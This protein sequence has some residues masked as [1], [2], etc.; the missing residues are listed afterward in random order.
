MNKLQSYMYLGVMVILLLAVAVVWS[1][2]REMTLNKENKSITAIKP[3]AL[4]DTS[5]TPPSVPEGELLPST[6]A[7]G[8]GSYTNTRY[9][10][11]FR[12]LRKEGHHVVTDEANLYTYN[13]EARG[14]IIGLE[15]G[16][17]PSHMVIRQMGK[18]MCGLNNKAY[19]GYTNKQVITLMTQLP[20]K[21]RIALS[22]LGHSTI[23]DLSAQRSV[24]VPIRIGKYTGYGFVTKDS[25]SECESTY[26]DDNKLTG[27]EIVYLF[28]ETKDGS[29]IS[30][31]YPRNSRMAQTIVS[32]LRFIE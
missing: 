7:D 2:R 14:M 24:I 32:T 11:T 31:T 30:I 9:G 27:V 5:I 19:P 12:N 1:N 25:Y 17:N 3:V 15:N 4:T 16:M 6:E 29:Y 8:W 26:I 23:P 28:F 21:D 20:F 13:E 10:I 18:A 22:V